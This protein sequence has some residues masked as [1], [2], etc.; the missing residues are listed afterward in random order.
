MADA[1]DMRIAVSMAANLSYRDSRLGKMGAASPVRR[2]DPVTGEVL[3]DT[4]MAAPKPKPARYLRRRGYWQ[5][6]LEAKLA[7]DKA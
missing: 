6:R 3:P 2:I 4:A 7:D 5:K 1:R